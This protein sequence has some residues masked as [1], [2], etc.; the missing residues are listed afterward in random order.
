[1]HEAEDLLA[2][3]APR[4]RTD[5]EIASVANARSYNLSTL[6]GNMNAGVAVAEEALAKVTDPQQR[7]RLVGL[8]A[9]THLQAGDVLRALPAG[10]EI[11]EAGGPLQ[12][13][14]GGYVTSWALGMLGRSGE[15]VDVATR[16]R[17]ELSALDDPPPRL[18]ALLIGSF[19]GHWSA[20]ELDAALVDADTAYETSL[21]GSDQEGV[22]THALLRGLVG[23]D[24][25]D[26]EAAARSFREGA[27]INREIN[28]P[29]VLRWCLGGVAMAEG[30][31]GNAAEA[32]E[33]VGELEQLPPHWMAVLSPVLVD[34]GLAWAK[35]GLGETS[36]A[37][38]MLQQASSGA[39]E[40][41]HAPSE[42]RLLHDIA[43]LGDPRSVVTRLE[44]LSEIVQ[45]DLVPTMAS[46]ARALV[47]RSGPDLQ[48]AA[49]TFERMGARMLAAE[50]AAAA[51]EAFRS[52]GYARQA[53]A[54]L[55]KSQTLGLAATAWT[56]AAVPTGE[57]VRLSRREHEIAGLAASGSSNQEIA[58]RLYLSVRTVQNHL[59]RIYVKLGVT[60]R[61]E[62]AAALGVG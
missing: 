21:A 59:H 62:L 46:H 47:A 42:A 30:M 24:R 58:E 29:A 51:S 48:E 23:V 33:A 57:T 60:R 6:L 11:L 36:A 8:L 26:Y 14:R 45:G 49:T 35:A 40:R 20:G 5:A 18:E 43:R 32:G 28:D 54:A 16:A 15:A 13:R 41:E 39:R 12:V 1:A 38:E 17:A 34:R 7:L 9:T 27:A 56:S 52:A 2:S 10:R 22:A 44:E 4:C 53:A 25:G 50:A 31:H 55:R 3:V 61:E 37:R 19:F